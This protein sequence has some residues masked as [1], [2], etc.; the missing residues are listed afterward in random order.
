MTS[1]ISETGTTY[2][3]RAPEFAPRFLVKQELLTVPEHQSL[4]LGF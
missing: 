1:A 4:P 2:G 3:S